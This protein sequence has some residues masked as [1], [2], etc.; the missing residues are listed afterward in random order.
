MVK[1]ITDMNTGFGRLP[2]ASEQINGF[3]RLVDTSEQVNGFG[4]LPDTREQVNGI[5][6]LPT[7]GVERI[8]G[9]L[10]RLGAM[11]AAAAIPSAPMLK[12]PP[13][14][15]I[16]ASPN[17]YAQIQSAVAKATA[18]AKKALAL[19]QS[20]ITSL[21][22]NERRDAGVKAVQAMQAQRNAD[23]L[24]QSA[25][26]TAAVLDAEKQAAGLEREA[27]TIESKAQSQVALTGESGVTLAMRAQASEL[28]KRAQGQRT[29]AAVA[30]S[31]KPAQVGPT[32]ER[33]AQVAAK[34]DVRTRR[35]QAISRQDDA[36]LL[37]TLQGVEE[38]GDSVMS[39]ESAA[40]AYG[41][42]ELGAV[43]AA[44]EQRNIPA[45]I[46]VLQGLSA[47]PA[48]ARPT[49]MP[50][51]LSASARAL[52]ARIRGELRDGEVM[53]LVKQYRAQPARSLSPAKQEERMVVFIEARRRGLIKR[54]RK[55][56]MWAQSRRLLPP[57]R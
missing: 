40:D 29:K 4:R 47:V 2:D 18:E 28:R 5:G 27:A 38:E 39:A 31:S 10:G 49:V 16:E 9:G 22:L 44:A 52:L 51:P 55:A 23:Q 53:A 6:R 26:R 35:A 48:A 34:F 20:A 37:A 25:M 33:I 8:S 15:S 21:R 46:S 42:D 1:D 56:G 54:P 11:G 12:T 7:D 45:F 24:A 13:R 17:V 41:N 50:M 57:S 43:L 3:G 30:L 19:K 14:S 36:V 32:N